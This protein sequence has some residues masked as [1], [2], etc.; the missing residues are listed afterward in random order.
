[1]VTS[2]PEV[3]RSSGITAFDQHIPARILSAVSSGDDFVVLSGENGV[4]AE[5]AD[6]AIVR[7]HDAGFD[8]VAATAPLPRLSV[9][10]DAIRDSMTTRKS[11]R[12][13][14][15]I[16]ACAEKLSLQTMRRL[17]TLGRLRQAE[18]PVLRF[19]LTG[20]PALWP[21][22]RDAGLG[23]LED[24][25]AAH[26]RLMPDSIR[27]LPLL[28][29]AEDGPD[30]HLGFALAGPVQ[31]ELTAS[32]PYGAGRTRHSPG[33]PLRMRD[34]PLARVAALAT[35][36]LTLAG[37]GLVGVGLVT[38]SIMMPSSHL[39]QMPAPAPSAVGQAAPP[40][41]VVQA[42]PMSPDDRLAVLLDRERKQIAADG[43]RSPPSVGLLETRRQIDEILPQVSS[44]ALHALTMQADAAAG[45]S[46]IVV[47]PPIGLQE[48]SQH[49]ASNADAPSTSVS[50]SGLPQQAG[51]PSDDPADGP[52][53][54]TLRYSRGDS[55]AAAQAMRIR[56]SLRAKGVSVDG[57][58][59]LDQVTGQSNLGYYFAQDQTMATS[60]AQ[61]LLPRMPQVRKMAAPSGTSLP[62]PGEI[63]IFI[64][65]DAA[66]TLV[67]SGKQT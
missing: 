48:P 47:A 42:A 36:G 33:M 28:P 49:P 40:R 2:T 14:V 37:I 38:R 23:S 50:S 60:L 29:H 35:V 34:R 5:I 39:P 65:S 18:R 16:V 59:A 10:H 8:T 17:I 64:G 54:V 25:A 31:H 4:A 11:E 44:R 13:L 6:A 52:M 3:A 15:V 56:T 58:V 20:T 32:S 7:L 63:S 22:L 55:A 26:F 46:I 9:L 19:L 24:D 12:P 21:V 67:S 57:P 66:A 51:A 41:A 27:C 45:R 61:R 1:M 43:T 62:R 30:R 53:H